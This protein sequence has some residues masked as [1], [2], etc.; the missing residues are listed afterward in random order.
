MTTPSDAPAD[1][2]S[3]PAGVQPYVNAIGAT[4]A[5][6]LFLRFGG[7]TI[8]LTDRPRP[9]SALVNV[10]GATAATGLF[11]EFG[12]G[13]V[14]VPMAKAWIARQLESQG[15]DRAEI[16]RRLHVTRESVRGYLARQDGSG[17][18][19][20]QLG[21]KINVDTTGVYRGATEAREA[22]RAATG[23]TA[24]FAAANSICGLISGR[25]SASKS[26]TS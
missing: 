1:T 5:A 3:A 4:A 15:V 20:L 12:R 19:T 8:Y 17:G 7:T 21:I 26:T 22:I 6:E 23:A 16:A 13:H 10:I 9:G 14:K 11:R 18:M 25:T 24:G 2:P